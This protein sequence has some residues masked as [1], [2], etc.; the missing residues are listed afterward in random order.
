MER[1][2]RIL[3]HQTGF[4]YAIGLA[5]AVTIYAFALSF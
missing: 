3:P 5:V 4:L 2:S 1:P